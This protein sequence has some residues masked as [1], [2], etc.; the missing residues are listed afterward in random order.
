MFLAAQG[1]LVGA[2]ARLGTFPT[3]V[4]SALALEPA[5]DLLWEGLAQMEAL[6]GQKDE[7]LR[8]ARKAVEF[9]AR[10]ARLP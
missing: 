4:R 10:V 5:N 6:L 2:R 9:E 7:A 1:D 3:E 8:D